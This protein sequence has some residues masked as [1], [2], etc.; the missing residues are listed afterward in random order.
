MLPQEVVEQQAPQ[1]LP[2]AL[3]FQVAPVSAASYC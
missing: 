3:T 1:L 2:L